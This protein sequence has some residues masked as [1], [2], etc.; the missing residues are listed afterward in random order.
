M[1]EHAAKEIAAAAGDDAVV[2]EDELDAYAADSSGA[3]SG[4]PSAAVR[5]A[6]AAGVARVLAAASRLRVPVVPAVG[7]ALS[8]L[9]RPAG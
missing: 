4:R 7:H 8:D 6:D 1:D 3:P 5:P 9:T 2:P